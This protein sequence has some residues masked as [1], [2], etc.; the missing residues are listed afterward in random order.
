LAARAWQPK[1][2]LCRYRLYLYPAEIFKTG[3]NVK[4]VSI[5]VQKFAQ[6][7]G[8]LSKLPKY[9]DKDAVGNP[10]FTALFRPNTP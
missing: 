8:G 4:C 3:T 7:N 10:F 2:L 1:S 5:T 9:E 6:D